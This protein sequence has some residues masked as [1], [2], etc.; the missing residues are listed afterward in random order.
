MEQTKITDNNRL[1]FYQHVYPTVGMSRNELINLDLYPGNK[2]VFDSA[3]WHY[4][5]S[6]N[7]HTVIKY[8]QLQTCKNYNL[9]RDKFDYI[10]DGNKIPK[11]KIFCNTLLLDNS[12]YL[13]YKST[14]ELSDSLDILASTFTPNV[15]VIRLN[16][17]NLGDSRLV[18]RF[19]NFVNLFPKDY[20][21]SKFH[22]T[23]EKT[24][25]LFVELLEK[26]KYDFN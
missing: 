13:K 24:S 5:D 18:D 1:E 26:G 8:E 3:G 25:S 9:T 22:Y 2:L 6:F 11:A 14:T 4:A 7:E 19:T 20:L 16:L 10:F 12:P 17:V 21:V 23:A 15:I